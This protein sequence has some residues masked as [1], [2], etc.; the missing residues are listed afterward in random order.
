MYVKQRLPRH[1]H[2]AAGHAYRRNSPTHDEV[3]GESCA[4]AHQ[5]VHVGSLDLRIIQ[6]VE[7]TETLIVCK[8][9]QD[10]GPLLLRAD[11]RQSQA[12]GADAGGPQEL[13]SGVLHFPR[14]AYYHTSPNRLLNF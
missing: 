2:A 9:D 7:R 10:V 12:S 6:C 5:P 13:S 11:T 1:E 4:A 3:V 8:E 14:I